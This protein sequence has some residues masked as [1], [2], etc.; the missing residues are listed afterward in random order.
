MKKTIAYLLLTVTTVIWGFAFVAQENA[1]VIP[2]FYVGAVRCLLAAVMLLVAMPIM[3]ALT[4]SKRRLITPEKRI[5][6]NRHELI[7]GAILGVII[8]VATGFQQYGLGEGTDSGKAAFITALYVV[9]VPIISSILGKRPSLFAIISI[10]LAI[11]GSYFLCVKSGLS[12]A[13][14][15]ALVLVC[16]IVFACHII[17]VDRFSPRCDGV[18][19]S[20]IQFSV[21]FVLNLILALIFEKMPSWESAMA[22]MPSLLYLGI[23]SSGVGYTLQ[24]IGQRD[25]DPTLASMIMSLES[26]FGVIGAMIFTGKTMTLRELL[27]CGIMLT[28]ILLAQLNKEGLKR[29]FVRKKGKENEKS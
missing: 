15:D 20:F 1:T 17:V 16:A 2:P 4:K 21:S 22:V 8:T 12:L 18:R 13:F 3:D 9:F 26:V 24:I 10:P 27:G 25:T 29:L 28:A 5:D 11:V 6:F 14:S 7:G 19:M 23:L